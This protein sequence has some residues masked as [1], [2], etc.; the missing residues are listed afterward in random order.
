MRSEY[1]EARS[2][3]GSIDLNRLVSDR[4]AALRARRARLALGPI[5]R[6]AGPDGLESRRAPPTQTRTAVARSTMLST[7]ARDHFICRYSHCRKRTIYIPVLRE[8]SALFPDVIPYDNNWR[9]LVSHI[10][11]WTYSASLEHRISFPHGGT[12]DLENLITACYQC[13][14]IKNMIRASDLGWEVTEIGTSDWD[15]LSSYLAALKEVVASQPTVRTR[16][17]ALEGR[18]NPGLVRPGG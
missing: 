18:T 1:G 10:L 16:N 15:G 6:A 3:L 7:F 2:A 8:L 14:D 4:K 9:P 11:Y 12:S 13:N 5:W 17:R